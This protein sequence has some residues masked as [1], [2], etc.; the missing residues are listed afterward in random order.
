MSSVSSQQQRRLNAHL[1]H[2]AREAEIET[3]RR[4]FE[5]MELKRLEHLQLRERL[6]TLD[7]DH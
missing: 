2:L 1:E 4:R 7:I 5:I 3:N 6:L